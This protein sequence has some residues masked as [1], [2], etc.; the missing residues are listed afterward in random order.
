MGLAI[1]AF[2]IPVLVA[3]AVVAVIAAH[4]WLDYQR[5]SKAHWRLQLTE[6]G[7]GCW[8]G[9]EAFT[10]SQVVVRQPYL[11]LFALRTGQHKQ[12]FLVT[13][14]QLSERQHRN[15]CRLLG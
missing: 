6:Q 2:F 14:G 1:T 3:A 13:K 10:V 4:A 11:V 15:L 12:W 7:Q 8:Y 5:L 9:S